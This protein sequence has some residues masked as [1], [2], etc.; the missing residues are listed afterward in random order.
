MNDNHRLYLSTITSNSEIA[1][2]VPRN[3]E[4]N[5]NVCF[6]HFYLTLQW[7]LWNVIKYKI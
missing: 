5:T 2:A 4:E 6:D 1:K 3:Q 7:G